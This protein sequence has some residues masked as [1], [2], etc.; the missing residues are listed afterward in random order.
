MRCG[1]ALRQI[2]KEGRAFGRN[3]ESIV[4]AAHRVKVFG[5]RLLHDRKPR[6]DI[7]RYA[8]DQDQ[9]ENAGVLVS[10]SAAIRI[11]QRDFTPE[12]LAAEIAS[13]AGDPTRLAHMAAAARS[14]GASDAAERLADV[15]MRVAGM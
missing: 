2:G 9:F 14:A 11:E 8:L 13:L 7:R 5:A 3:A 4:S 12:R 1:H 15:V 10:A 6:P